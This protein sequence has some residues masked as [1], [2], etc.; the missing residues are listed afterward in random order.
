MSDVQHHVN[1]N[2]IFGR[3]CTMVVTFD[4][5]KFTRNVTKWQV[6]KTDNKNQ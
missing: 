3:Q 6:T 2:S 1:A 4:G 5:S